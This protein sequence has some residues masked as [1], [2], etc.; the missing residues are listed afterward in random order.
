MY[1]LLCAIL[2]T[3]T[4]H[5][6]NF[7]K[8][9]LLFLI[10]NLYFIFLRVIFCIEVIQYSNMVLQFQV[11]MTYSITIWFFVEMFQF[12]TY[13]LNKYFSTNHKVKD[14][15][16]YVNGL[17]QNNRGVEKRISKFTITANFSVSYDPI[18]NYHKKYNRFIVSLQ[19]EYS[20][21]IFSIIFFRIILLLIFSIAFI[22]LYYASFAAQ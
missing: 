9:F 6:V 14:I 16:I 19:Y 10:R 20:Y 7:F 5:I 4:I 22:I 2:T 18:I 8:K 3:V 21:L 15:L 12:C 11:R 17:L 13:V 1:I